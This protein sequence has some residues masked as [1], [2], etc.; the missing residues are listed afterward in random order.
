MSCTFEREL[1]V[2]DVHG[3]AAGRFERQKVRAYQQWR[4]G[5][6]E[7]CGTVHFQYRQA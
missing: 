4:D 5:L 1:S 7:S 2:G 6:I 3:A